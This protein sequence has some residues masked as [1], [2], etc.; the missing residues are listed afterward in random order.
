MIAS[1]KILIIDDDPSWLS[2]IRTLLRL[3]GFD[4]V[5]VCDDPVKLTG[6]EAVGPFDLV[7]LDLHMPTLDGETVLE[8][9]KGRHPEVPVCILTASDSAAPAVRCLRAGAD[10]YLVKTEAGER[11]VFT[12]R[13]LLA[14][15][16]VR[17]ENQALRRALLSAELRDPDIFA[18]ILTVDVGMEKI[19]RYVESVA[20]SSEPVLI[21]GETGTGKELIA[22]AVHRCSG[23]AGAFVPVNVGGLDD[24]L[25]AD[26]LFG[27]KRGAFTGAVGARPGM[28]NRAAG[29]TLFLDEIGEMEPASQV[30]L[31]RL[32]Q[33]GEFLPLGCDRSEECSARIVA[34]T[35]CDLRS[36]RERAAFRCDLY[37]R[38]RMHSV[39]VPPLRERSSDI[40][41]LF[42][43]FLGEAARSL[44][45]P[46]PGVEEDAVRLLCSYSFPGNV[47]ELRAISHDALARCR[48]AVIDVPSIRELLGAGTG[49][50]RRSAQR[51]GGRMARR[52][53]R[54]YLQ[55]LDE[56]PSL[57]QVQEDLVIEA[58]NR[59]DGSQAEAA[60]ML[61]V[62]RQAL[63]QRVRK[64]G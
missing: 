3:S 44:C 43:H 10:D 1:V 49:T 18:D 45:C 6:M 9:I 23:R 15:A 19:F 29:G 5:V 30:K 51:G 53:A 17:M 20:Q 32:L 27:H 11:L 25:F 36:A 61:G 47:R 4:H 28:A 34:A 41:L 26:T 24:A 40:P 55:R 64:R 62:S 48:D 57:R 56:L 52:D 39:T 63:N 7:L 54:A 12:V 31:L 50:F 58:L 60:R 2:S 21:M 46:L 13:K 16:A 42:R 35:H 59:S 14:N 33:E 8:Q 38:L 37:Y 22:R